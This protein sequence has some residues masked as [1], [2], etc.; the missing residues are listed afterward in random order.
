MSTDSPS[1]FTTALED[2]ATVY[3]TPPP[4]SNPP[5]NRAPDSQP[6]PRFYRPPKQLPFELS[7]HACVFLGSGQYLEGLELLKS[8]LTSGGS[9]SSPSN[10]RPAF[11]PPTQIFEFAATLAVHPSTTTRASNI[12]KLRAANEALLYL[13]A[14]NRIV[15]P[16]N[17]GFANAFTFCNKA[18]NGKRRGY[19]DVYSSAQTNGQ[20]AAYSRPLNSA[21]ANGSSVW[22]QAH[23]FWDIVGWAFNCSIKYK[24]RWSRWQVWLEVMLE[25]L[26]DDWRNRHKKYKEELKENGASSA[27]IMTQSIM[28]TYLSNCEAWAVT[29]RRRILSA[30]FADGSERSL[31]HFKE[32]FEDELRERA[33]PKSADSMKVADFQ[34]AD[35]DALDPDEDEDL[36]EETTPPT[37]KSSRSTAKADRRPSVIT[38]ASDN[39]TTPENSSP[40]VAEPFGPPAALALRVR[41]LSLLGDVLV[42]LPTVIT[43]REKLFDTY[44]EYLRPLPI[45][46]F[47]TMLSALAAHLSSATF[48]IL[49]ANTLLPLISSTPP[50]YYLE[51]PTQDEW[52]EYFLPFAARTPSVTDNAKVSVLLRFVVQVSL[53]GIIWRRRWV[54]A[55]FRGIKA[56]HDKIESGKINGRGRGKSGGG[57]DRVVEGVL[58]DNE[59]TLICFVGWVEDGAFTLPL[60]ILLLLVNGFAEKLVFN[61]CER[62]V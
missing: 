8:L 41:L 20:N 52:E 47:T 45:T 3:L 36:I 22:E 9:I 13:R 50:T 33:K 5:Q 17:A 16:V 51:P 49:A 31:A 44:T 35:L 60:N 7:S 26:E 1:S 11:I 28:A 15:G 19:S 43:T 59:S 40:P 25:I 32:V 24:A 53:P 4:T 21:L 23:D 39:S 2:D 58:R 38:I 29:P 30:I 34:T 6:A 54:E 14:V 37:R 48:C 46:S 57:D 61:R 42:A 18:R 12:T 27:E 55:V 62:S 56:R 10:P